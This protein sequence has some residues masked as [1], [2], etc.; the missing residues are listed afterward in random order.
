MG[1]RHGGTPSPSW[2]QFLAQHGFE[3]CACDLVAD[4]DIALVGEPVEQGPGHLRATEH[5]NRQQ[6]A[7]KLDHYPPCAAMEAQTG[8]PSHVM[9]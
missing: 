3:I 7:R 4:F 1:R 9:R 2:R 8:N 5:G 6:P